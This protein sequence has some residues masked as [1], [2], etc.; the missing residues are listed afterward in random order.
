MKKNFENLLNLAKEGQ[1]DAQ[2]QLLPLVYDELK[3]SAQRLMRSENSNHTLQATALLHEAYFKINGASLDLCQNK[4]HF[5]GLTVRMMRQ[6][7]CDHARSKQAE[8]RGGG[9]T[10]LSLNDELAEKSTHQDQ[11][12]VL[13][14]HDCLEKLAQL[15]PRQAQLVELRYFG[16]L[17]LEECA[18]VLQCSL[19]TVKRD[20][21]FARA[22]M[23]K[24]LN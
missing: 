12:D 18:D 7:L 9:Q 5:V 13:I 1:V 3:K 10:L 17:E 21:V 23:A 15:D 4:A 19:A 8:K 20:W 11:L 2:A 22:W 14:L 16:G 6:I 24:E